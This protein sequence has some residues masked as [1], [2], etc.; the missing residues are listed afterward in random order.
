MSMRRIMTSS[1]PPVHPTSTS[2]SPMEMSH[3]YLYNRSS[4][5]SAA[6]SSMLPSISTSHNDSYHYSRHNRMLSSSSMSSTTVTFPHKPSQTLNSEALCIRSRQRVLATTPCGFQYV[7]SPLSKAVRSITKSSPPIPPPSPPSETSSLY[8]YPSFSNAP[9]LPSSYLSPTSHAHQK[10]EEEDTEKRQNYHRRTMLATH[11]PRTASSTVPSLPDWMSSPSH[12]YSPSSNSPPSAQ[13]NDSMSPSIVPATSQFPNIKDYAAAA[14]RY[15][16]AWERA[17]RYSMHHSPTHSNHSNS[18]LSPPSSY[19]SMNTSTLVRRTA[20]PT[21]PPPS[22]DKLEHEDKDS[23]PTHNST[24]QSPNVSPSPY[25]PSLAPSWNTSNYNP[26]YSNNNSSIQKTFSYYDSS[27]T[28]QQHFKK[29][30]EKYE[31]DTSYNRELSYSHSFQQYSH[32]NSQSPNNDNEIDKSSHSRLVYSSEMEPN[33]SASPLHNTATPDEVTIGMSSN[34]FCKLTIAQ[35]D[36]CILVRAEG[37]RQGTLVLTPTHLIFRY[38]DMMDDNPPW[39]GDNPPFTEEK[40]KPN[41]TN[42]RLQPKNVEEEEEVDEDSG[43]EYESGF[44]SDDEMPLSLHPNSS[45]YNAEVHPIDDDHPTS[46]APPHQREN[47]LSFDTNSQKGEVVLPPQSCFPTEGGKEPEELWL[48]RIRRERARRKMERGGDSTSSSSSESSYTSEEDDASQTTP[49][50]QSSFPPFHSQQ[51]KTT[52]STSQLYSTPPPSHVQNGNLS[53]YRDISLVDTT[54]ATAQQPQHSTQL[55]PPPPPKLDTNDSY[56]DFMNASLI[57]TIQEEARRRLR[58]LEREEND[59]NFVSERLSSSLHEPQQQPPSPP[60]LPVETPLMTCAS[61]TSSASCGGWWEKEQLRVIEARAKSYL[62]KLDDSIHSSSSSLSQQQ[63]QE[64]LHSYNHVVWRNSDQFA[65]ST[66]EHFIQKQHPP[67]LPS[68]PREEEK[69][70]HQYKSF[71]MPIMPSITDG[72]NFVEVSHND[73]GEYMNGILVVH[74]G[75]EDHSHKDIEEQSPPPSPPPP[76]PPPSQQVG[77]KEGEKMRF[78]EVK[79][80]RDDAFAVI[81]VNQENYDAPPSP[82]SSQNLSNNATTKMVEQEQQPIAH[83]E[84]TQ[85]EVVADEDDDWWYMT[86]DDEPAKKRRRAKG[87]KWPLSKLAE[88]YPR[89]YMM[90]DVAMEIFAPSPTASTTGTSD[91]NA[92]SI[93]SEKESFLLN[94]SSHSLASVLSS[95]AAADQN[96]DSVPISKL[97]KLSFY[98]AIPD[99]PENDRTTNNDDDD[100]GDDNDFNNTSC[101]S[102]PVTN[103]IGHWREKR[104]QRQAQKKKAKSSSVTNNISRRETVLEKLKEYVPSLNMAY[105]HLMTMTKS[106]SLTRSLGSRELATSIGEDNKE[107]GSDGGGARSWMPTSLFRRRG[108]HRASSGGNTHST[109]SNALHTLTRAWRKGHI[110]NYD[111]LIRLNA[112]AGRSTHDPSLYPVMPWV[113]SNYTSETVPDLSDERNYRDMTRPM[114]ALYPDRLRKFMDKYLSLCSMVDSAIPPFMYG[115]HYSSTGGV[116]LHFL[117]RVRPFAGLHRQ[118]QGGHFDVAD[119]LFYS[120]PHTWDMCART[121]PTEV[122]ELTPEWYSDPTFLQNKHGFNLGRRVGGKEIGDVELPPWANGS[123]TK[124]IEVMQNALESDVCS[125]ML[126]AWID[127]IFGYKQNGSDARKAHNVFYHLTYYDTEDLAKIEDEALRTEMELHIA[128]FGHCPMQLF[129]KSHPHK[130]A[131]SLVSKSKVRQCEDMM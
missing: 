14:E 131:A 51:P 27:L 90:R 129:F 125:T 81:A 50:S 122:K 93:M 119:R 34:A 96:G 9:P 56:E 118:L 52:T 18:H 30:E 100:E 114:G 73:T 42:V 29:E 106:S 25:N 53:Y 54:T 79:K 77:L 40:S 128:D 7:A 69:E 44:D 46:P 5:K 72:G 98:I 33:S 120:I 38:D 47:P 32:V 37:G 19:S 55:P 78:D 58:E 24:S 2:S 112:I 43:S 64:E 113:L 74:G 80:D 62:Q 63:Q 31:E 71:M 23:K 16:L 84:E 20:K 121:S 109:N 117:L 126:P 116:V 102:S 91:Q 41:Q 60:R 65:A 110:S 70:T 124:F 67:S 10:A 13:L 26:A 104:S 6:I 76:P 21:P 39:E 97:S 1:P 49:P 88:A 28:K 3:S 17:R 99:I 85:V 107:D 57:R 45:I 87:I 66:E 8:P 68:S 59:S 115:S 89:T 12:H 75:E 61:S 92:N 127:L 94:E 103:A 105:W 108:Y 101:S 15:Y 95:N 130:K 4:P 36:H 35:W 83:D 22:L 48:M 111:Y 11:Y 82:P 86:G 123:P